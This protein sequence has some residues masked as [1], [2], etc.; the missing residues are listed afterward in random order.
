MSQSHPELFPPIEP[1]SKDYLDVGD[2]HELYLE[3]C[4][5]SD[6]L[7]VVFLHGGPGG[8]IGPDNRRFFDPDRYRIIL[9]D[10]RG[11]GQS[12]PLAEIA[13]NTTDHVVADL[14][15]I[16]EHLGIDRWLIFGGSW[17]ST[18]GLVY[19]QA[20][21]NRCLGLILRG[22]FLNR[23]QDVDWLYRAGTGRVYPEAWERLCSLIPAPERADLPAAYARRINGDD[24]ELARKAAT[25]WA[26]FEGV[27]A[28][29]KPNPELVASFLEPDAAWY[30]AR[31]C[32]HYFAH[33]LFL[34]PNQILE[35][36]DRI[37]SVPAILVH[38]RHDMICVPEQAWALHR[39]WP[40]SELIWIDDAGHSATE[41]GT[42]SALVAAC[43]RFADDLGRT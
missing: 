15:R 27:C 7:P 33:R 43:Q 39:A 26:C 12:K 9:F 34:A 30:F 23:P 28:T 16:R 41:P 8:G 25:E 21:A 18:L 32:T 20:Y 2:G 35:R 42:T 10:Q 5:R 14:E 19:A 1:W 24:V 31:I 40:G 17:G 22:I 29:L 3:Q 4:G 37:A 13:H 11:A 38:G 36:M 6:G